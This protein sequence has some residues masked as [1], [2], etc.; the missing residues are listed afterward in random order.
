MASSRST[1]STG[2]MMARPVDPRM[3]ATSVAQSCKMIIL[4]MTFGVPRRLPGRLM[5]SL[6]GMAGKTIAGAK[7]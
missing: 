2:A 7:T 1:A 5:A 4:R 3:P 6:P